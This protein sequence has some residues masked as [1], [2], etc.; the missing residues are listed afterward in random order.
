MSCRATGSTLVI[1]VSV[2]PKVET[3]RRATYTHLFKTCCVDKYI[4][5]MENTQFPTGLQVYSETLYWETLNRV[6]VNGFHHYILV[7][8]SYNK[9]QVAIAKRK[10]LK[11]KNSLSFVFNIF[12]LINYYFFFGC[13]LIGHST[14]M[15]RD[16]C[17]CPDTESSHSHE[18]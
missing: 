9:L 7:H 17:F 18:F 10:S 3:K 15:M 14:N 2:D 4:Y 12:F 6:Q 8:R 5:A 1:S 11:F 13:C 16:S